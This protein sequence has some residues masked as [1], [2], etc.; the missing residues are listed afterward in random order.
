MEHG[1]KELNKLLYKFEKMSIKEYS[2]L[3]RKIYLKEK[4]KKLKYF[5]ISILR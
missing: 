1:K 2:N 4:I 5:I 3:Y